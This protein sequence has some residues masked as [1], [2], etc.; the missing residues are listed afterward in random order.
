[1]LSMSAVGNDGRVYCLSKTESSNSAGYRLFMRDQ[2]RQKRF[3]GK[4]SYFEVSSK[5]FDMSNLTD[6]ERVTLQNQV[7]AM[8]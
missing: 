7:S 3:L 5:T 1:M 6:Q 4:Y 8:Q 2:C